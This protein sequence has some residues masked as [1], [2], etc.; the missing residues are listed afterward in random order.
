M[1]GC[2]VAGI[3]TGVG[4]T[5]VAAIVAEKWRADYWKPV[6]AGE[7]HASD[8]MKARQLAPEAVRFQC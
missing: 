5:V 7:L 8:T 3:G 4:K 6:Q 2:V 1:H